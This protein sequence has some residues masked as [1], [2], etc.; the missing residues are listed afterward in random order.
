MDDVAIL[1]AETI[2]VDDIGNEVEAKHERTVF[3][4]TRSIT[5]NEFY[6]ASEQGLRPT[7]AIVL[8]TQYD[9]QGERLVR[10]HGKEY[11]VLRTYQPVDSDELELTLEEK[12]GNYGEMGTGVWDRCRD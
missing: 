2:T 12:V 9:Y 11:T 5:R 4:R 6:Q 8:S 1:V 3:C 10:W 7:G